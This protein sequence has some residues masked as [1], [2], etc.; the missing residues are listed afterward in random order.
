MAKIF[1]PPYREEERSTNQ[2]SKTICCAPVRMP[3]CGR[4]FGVAKK[5][6]VQLCP[7]TYNLGMD[8]NTS[9]VIIG[10]AVPHERHVN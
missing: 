1:F 10:C 4:Q 6:K 8:K 9:E 5:Y 3:V 2:Q 7:G